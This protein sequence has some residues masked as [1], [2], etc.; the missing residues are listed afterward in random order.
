MAISIQKVVMLSVS[1]LVIGLI[2]PL[3]L[4][5]IA[6]AGNTNVVVNGTTYT[7]SNIVDSSV[8]TLLTVLIPIL[9]V[10]GIAIAYIKFGGK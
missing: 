7:L 4:A 3:G 9:A 1:L 10:I 5:Y 2:M 8:L 6:N